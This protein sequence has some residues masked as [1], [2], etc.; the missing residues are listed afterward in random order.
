MLKIE[1]GSYFK[2]Q[3]KK[4]INELMKFKQN[5]KHFVE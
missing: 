3:Q 2:F 5:N 4:L 1:R